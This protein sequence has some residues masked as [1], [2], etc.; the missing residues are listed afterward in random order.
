M[1]ALRKAVQRVDVVAIHVAGGGGAGATRRIRRP[2][3]NPTPKTQKRVSKLRQTRHRRPRLARSPRL[4]APPRAVLPRLDR[5]VPHP[6]VRPT[7]ARREVR[8]QSPCLPQQLQRFRRS[9]RTLEMH[10]PFRFQHRSAIRQAQQRHRL[11]VTDRR[12]R[13]VAF[14]PRS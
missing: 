13:R 1:R 3:S 9:I 2:S 11:E 4:L 14:R 5:R 8:P 6:R 12:R 10:P 7:T